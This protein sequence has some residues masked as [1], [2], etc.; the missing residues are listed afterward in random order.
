[1]QNDNDIR[2]REQVDRLGYPTVE[3]LDREIA[4][5][6][7]KE[8]YKRLTRGVLIGLVATA[9]VIIVITSLWVTVLQIDGSSMNPLLRMD[10]IVLVIKNDHPMKNDIIAFY[11]N[12]TLLVKRVIGTEDDQIEINDDGVVSVNGQVQNEPY[13]TELSLGNCD[14]SFPYIVPPGTVFVLGDNRPVALDSRESRLGPVSK[15]QIVGVVKFR[16]WPL[17][18]IGSIS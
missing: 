16:V 14:I 15:D 11:Q 12:N 17:P 1:M 2:I 13:V 7:R 4:R 5:Q 3:M 10:E 9:A 18:R 8:S 6:E